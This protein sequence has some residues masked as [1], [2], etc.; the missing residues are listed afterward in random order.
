MSDQKS[1]VEIAKRGLGAAS[2]LQFDERPQTPKSIRKYRK[3]YFDEPGTRVTHP[4]LIDDYEL[5]QSKLANQRLGSRSSRS[6]EH[7]EGIF[8]S[9]P[10]GSL[11]DYINE[12]KEAVYKTKRQEPLGKPYVRGHDFS[13]L[14]EE[15][16][17]KPSDNA[18]AV[19]YS[20]ADTTQKKS[21]QPVSFIFFSSFIFKKYLILKN[22]YF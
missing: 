11:N 6:G 3:S 19:I 14:R 8:Q 12:R 7:I 18:K 1:K 20:S 21:S 9:G 5:L 10:T 15:K 16:A 17:S 2:C 22:P 4:G 13:S